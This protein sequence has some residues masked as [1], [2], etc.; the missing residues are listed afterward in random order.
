MITYNDK[1][2][3]KEVE[4][5][6]QRRAWVKDSLKQAERQRVQDSLRVVKEIKE[7][8]QNRKQQDIV[9]NFSY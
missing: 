1:A 5:Y 8:E 2:I 6:I 7:N 3:G 4:Q 9:D